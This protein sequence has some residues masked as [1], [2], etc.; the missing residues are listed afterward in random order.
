MKRNREGV[1]SEPRS[2]ATPQMGQMGKNKGPAQSR[3]K[4]RAGRARWLQDR[5]PATRSPPEKKGLA[6]SFTQQTGKLM[7]EYLGPL[8]LT[9]P[10]GLSGALCRGINKDAPHAAAALGQLPGC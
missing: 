1:I 9:Q 10:G 5:A 6:G 7:G 8:L 3:T 2:Q 4:G